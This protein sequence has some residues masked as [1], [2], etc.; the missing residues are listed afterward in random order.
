M[1][2]GGIVSND[3]PLH[4]SSA[5]VSP[6]TSEGP[7]ERVNTKIVARWEVAHQ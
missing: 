2:W 6:A 5:M 3:S 4:S 7:G 1:R